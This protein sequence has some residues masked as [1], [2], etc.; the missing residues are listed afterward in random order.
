[1]D[2][3]ICA[4]QSEAARSSGT[5]L[6]SASGKM[7]QPAPGGCRPTS[8]THKRGRF[9]VARNQNPGTSRCADLRWLSKYGIRCITNQPTV[10][11]LNGAAPIGR[12]RFR[13]SD[14]HDG[15]S[16]LAQ[17]T[18]EFHDFFG[19]KGMQISRRLIGEQE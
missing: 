6:N 16:V 13:V 17:V 11:Q 7:L 2:H 19:L 14:L 1:M 10:A 5:R 4:S 3:E 15:C 8:H 18:K 9:R 12:V